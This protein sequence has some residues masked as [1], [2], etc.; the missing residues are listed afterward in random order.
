MTICSATKQASLS[1]TILCSFLKLMS[2]DK[3]MPSHN[4]ILLFPLLL[5]KI[6]PSIKVYSKE[7]GLDT[8]GLSVGTSFSSSVIPLYISLP[9]KNKTHVSNH[10]TIFTTDK[11]CFL[12]IYFYFVFFFNFIF[13][14][15]YFTILYWFCHTLT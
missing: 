3:V 11:V 2:F 9:L 1:L 13:T 8:I 12:S 5:S 15:F 10:L 14:L 7:L 6:F 4:L